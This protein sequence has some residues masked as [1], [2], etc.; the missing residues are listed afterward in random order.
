MNIEHFLFRLSVAL[1][2]LFHFAPQ[3][4]AQKKVGLRWY[5]VQP[6]DSCWSIAQKLFGNPRKYTIIHKYNKL[7]PEPH[8]LKPGQR[9]RVPGDMALPD[10]RLVWLRRKVRARPPRSLD[11]LNAKRDMELWKLYQ[12][13]TGRSS[14][15]RIQFEDRSALR[16]REHALLVIYGRSASSSKLK[17]RARSKIV[18]K[19]GVVRG[20][21]ASLYKNA[22][23]TVNT[24]S[25]KVEIKGKEAQVEV[26][27]KKTSIVSVYQGT[28]DV[29][30]KGKTVRVPQE[31]GTFV[32]QGKK[33][34]KPRPLPKAPVWKHNK[35]RLVVFLPKGYRETFRVYW[36]P[37]KRAARYRVELSMDK[38]FSSV[39]VDAIVGAGVRGMK[40]EQ[41]LGGK[42]PLGFRKGRYFARV[43][44][45][46]E[47]KL[48]SKPSR[49]LEIQVVPLR[50]S[51]R[52]KRN[53]KGAYEVVGLLKL[54]P[55][56]S[57][58][59]YEF[60]H[61]QKSFVPYTSP[62][63]LSRPG[64]HNLRFRVKGEQASSSMDVRILRLKGQLKASSTPMKVKGAAKKIT[65]TVTDEDKKPA[66]PAGLDL[67]AY[68]GGKL[69]LTYQ[70]AGV[71]TATLP[72]PKSYHGEKIF[73]RLSWSG[74]D[75]AN[76]SIPVLAPPKPRVVIRRVVKRPP[77][78]RPKGYEWPEFPS[79]TEWSGAG[80]GP[81]RWAIPATFF[82]IS[83][84]LTESRRFDDARPLY[85]RF[86]FRGGVA[87]LKGKLGLDLDVPWLQINTAGES[88][89]LSKLGDIRLGARFVAL[90][91]E[92]VVLTP[93]LR[94][95][96]PTGGFVRSRRDLLV[97][98]GV[99]FEWKV[100]SW[101]RVNTNQVLMLGTDFGDNLSLFYVSSYGVEARF[102]KFVSV[103]LE[104]DM[105]IGLTGPDNV[106][107]QFGL[108]LSS[109]VRLHFDRL[110]VG[111]VG[112]VGLTD[113]ARMIMGGYTVGITLDVGF[114]GL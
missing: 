92:K 48:E 42:K 107:G 55:P 66:I 6:G 104:L 58:R 44:T 84:A 67:H 32:K 68:P 53:A 34:A 105:S 72:A 49:V 46:D 103:A 71:Y 17:R 20:G 69:A 90:Q 79:T 113:G 74:G 4:D 3:A 13:S 88:A 64:K 100:L 77:P 80:S 99:L 23:I 60:S 7:G 93:S 16:M 65:I 86:A 54:D 50:A 82:G 106:G 40:M 83:S 45:I 38:R 94:F 73:L 63:R 87:L 89:N 98:P 111:V 109:A 114:K 28:A 30:A 75:L 11:W 8:I 110:R 21:L 57:S 97:E 78:P 33:P 51:R 39:I 36:K 112:G 19:Q 96:F 2:V 59:E 47:D 85:F 35:K 31:F 12:V 18:V 9:L 81:S 52:L 10:A 5:T 43:A 25:G 14:A 102:L 26:D 56:S 70:R 95:T 61:N 1:F 91:M 41:D 101:L 76:T 22:G 27:K 62:I 24:P 37:A 108:G 15:A 29:S